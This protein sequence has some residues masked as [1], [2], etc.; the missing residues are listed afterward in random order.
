MAL[1]LV[2]FASVAASLVFGGLLLRAACRKLESPQ[3]PL[4]SKTQAVALFVLSAA[5]VLAPLWLSRGLH[6][7]DAGGAYGLSLLMAPVLVLVGLF[8][9]PTFETWAVAARRGQRLGWRSNDASP[10]RAVWLMELL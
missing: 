7:V 10:H 9:T 3:L 1:G 5:A 8:A 2:P 4:F 6:D